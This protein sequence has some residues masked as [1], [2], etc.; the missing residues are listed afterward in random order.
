MK[1]YQASKLLW[2]TILFFVV[3]LVCLLTWFIQ[4]VP[5]RMAKEMTYENYG[6]FR[7]GQ[8]VKM[9]MNKY[10]TGEYGSVRR[11]MALGMKNYGII[12]VPFGEEH[13]LEVGIAD[14][15]TLR[16]LQR[17]EDG[18]GPDCSLVV[19]IQDNEKYANG[20]DLTWYK[21][22]DVDASLVDTEFLYLET[23]E[24]DFMISLVA[25]AVGMVAALLSFLTIGGISIVYEKPFEDT[26]VYRECLS[27]RIQNIEWRIE[28]EQ[29]KLENYRR[30]RREAGSAVYVGMSIILLGIMFLMTGFL[31]MHG[32]LQM[33]GL[34]VGLW[35]IAWGMKVFWNGFL[36]SEHPSAYQISQM[37]MLKTAP[38]RVEE[39]LKILCALKQTKER[40][41]KEEQ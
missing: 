33:A 2:L 28:R 9:T 8:Y 37:F 23:V 4:V 30:Q 3:G 39:T 21:H 24:K 36:N 35:L 12:V 15:D 38:I 27:T 22:T 26:P 7:R 14:Q 10:V 18:E 29:E 17:Y 20:T 31:F 11:E 25:A 34:V 41:E 5:F 1:R 40:Q 6:T 32:I 19:R 16:L 13:Y